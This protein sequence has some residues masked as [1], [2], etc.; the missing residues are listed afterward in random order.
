M[1]ARL[2]KMKVLQEATPTALET[3]YNT[4]RLA[5]KEAEWVDSHFTDKGDNLV[6]V[7]LYTE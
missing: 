4:F 3:A 5:R 7:I 2:V 6:L 1:K